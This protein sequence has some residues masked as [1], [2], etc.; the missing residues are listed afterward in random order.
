MQMCSTATISK[1][2]VLAEL[3]CSAHVRTLK[4][5]ASKI[6]ELM[7]LTMEENQSEQWGTF[8]NAID[9]PEESIGKHF[10]LL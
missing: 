1:A 10:I 5:P 3:S 7:L 6:V 2:A 9:N 4:A 8:I